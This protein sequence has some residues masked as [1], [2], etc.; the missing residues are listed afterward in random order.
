MTDKDMEKAREITGDCQ[1]R[2]GYTSRKLIDHACHYHGMAD[3]IA[4]AIKAERE[5]CAAYCDNHQ[6]GIGARA[7]GQ[8]AGYVADYMPRDEMSEGRHPGMG[9][10]EAIRARGGRS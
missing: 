7:E 3:Q 5:A 4:A 1:C 10:A 6:T 9:Y 2:E 8:F